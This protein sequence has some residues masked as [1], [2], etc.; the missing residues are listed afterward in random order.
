MDFPA[1]KPSDNQS[2]L[3]GFYSAHKLGTSG[4]DRGLGEPESDPRQAG[5]SA[6]TLSFAPHTEVTRIR[7]HRKVADSLLRVFEEILQH[8]GSIEEVRTRE[9]IYSPVAITFG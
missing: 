7:C 4:N 5:L 1:F 8:F 2:E 9:C 6:L 3:E